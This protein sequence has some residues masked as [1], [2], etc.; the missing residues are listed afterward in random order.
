MKHSANAATLIVGDTGTGKTTLL[1]TVAEYVWEKYQKITRYYTSDPG[2][3]GDIMVALVR[4]GIV[5][6][7]RMR[8]RDPDGSRG[9]PIGTCSL[10]TAGYWPVE[11]DAGDTGD[12]PPGVELMAPSE[13]VFELVCACGDSSRTAG[14]KEGFKVAKPCP[15]CKKQMNA[16]TA[17]GIIKVVKPRPEFAHVGALLFDGLT[18]MSDWC[19]DDLGARAGKNQLGGEGSSIA[20]IHS[21]G[22]VYGTP[23]RAAIGFA[24]NRAHEWPLNASAVSGLLV[25]PVFTALELRATD[26]GNMPIYGP[27]LAGRAKTADAPSWFGN[28]LG[29]SLQEERGKTVH[30]LYLREY[31]DPG[32]SIPHL[33]K[34]RALGGTMPEYLQD[35]ENDAPNTQFHMGKFFD[36]LEAAQGKADERLEK[37]FGD[38][39]EKIAAMKAAAAEGVTVRR[40][41][42]Y[43]EQ[44]SAPGPAQAPTPTPQ[45][46]KPAAATPATPAASAQPARPAARPAAPR[47]PAAR[48]A[49]RPAQPAQPARPAGRPAPRPP[50][51]APTK[52]QKEKN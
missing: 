29:A 50:T 24:Q 35:E 42:A 6:V 45:P 12:C 47:P 1:A 20:A 19:M 28:C 49:A 39:R 10:A 38:V 13:V 14:S 3:F 27:K 17:K 31:R 37:K 43:Q 52:A 30:R 51:P 18:S 9:L 32:S 15:S 16:Q 22:V 23:N 25:P 33:C 5:E 40:E 26:E 46:Q 34:T 44:S 7:W 4:R 48:P 2:G 36:L 8:T 11:V 21:S 41:T